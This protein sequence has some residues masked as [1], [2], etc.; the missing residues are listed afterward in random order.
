MISSLD[1]IRGDSGSF[2]VSKGQSGVWQKTRTFL[3]LP[4][5]FL[6]TSLKRKHFLFNWSRSGPKHRIHFWT[7]F[8]K[9]HV[10]SQFAIAIGYFYDSFPLG[11]ASP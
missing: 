10:F 7:H 9:F 2:R 5:S 8:C 3:K 11:G 1:C 6:E 4:K